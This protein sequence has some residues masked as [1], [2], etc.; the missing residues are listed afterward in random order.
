MPDLRPRELWAVGPLIAVLIFFGVYPEAPA[1]RHQPGGAATLSQVHVT[2]P[3]PST[4]PDTRPSITGSGKTVAIAAAEGKHPVTGSLAVATITPPHIEYGQLSPLLL[5][6]GLGVVGVL[7]EAFVPRRPAPPRPPDHHAGRAGRRL[8]AHHR[9][10]RH[11]LALRPRRA[12]ERGGHGGGRGGRPDAVRV[13]H[14]PRARVRQRAADRGLVPRRT[15]RSWRRRPPPRA[16]PR[17]AP[18]SWPAWRTRRSTR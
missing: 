9:G 3:R 2:D 6:F 5:V 4:E 17:S 16:A 8:R 7:I 13:G 12:R 11:L 15:R 1:R 18:R 14:D 10:R